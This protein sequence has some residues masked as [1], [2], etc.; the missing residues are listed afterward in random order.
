MLKETLTTLCTLDG[1]SSDEGAVRA[2]LKEKALAAGATVRVDALGNL[3]CEKKGARPAVKP[4]MLCAHMDEVGL[5]VRRCTDEGFV[6]FDAVGGIDRRVLIGKPV[7]VGPKKVPGVIGLQAIHL[8]TKAER[9]KVAKLEEFYIDIGAKSRE[10]AE[11]LVSP[12]DTCS[13]WADTLEF[14][15]GLFKAK[16][17]DD[18]LGCAILCEL[19]NED[20]PTDVTFVFTVQEE[21]GT[22]GAFGATFSVKPEAAL[23]L[24]GT[25]AADL[26]GVADHKKVCYVGK[27]P[28]ISQ[29]DAATIYDR[30]LF[31]MLRNL[32][33]ENKIPWQTKELI[34]GGNDAKA[35]QRS[36][37]GVRVC[38]LSAPV[39]Y[40]HA[41]TS[42]VSLADCENMLKLA[43]LF[44]NAWAKRCLAEHQEGESG[45]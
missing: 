11:T 35:V 32:A 44:V 36:R 27:G 29:I 15:D 23:I 2:W 6:K 3:I 37:E 12:G 26:P 16:A 30:G 45:R 41:P 34:A 17:I 5:M 9:D 22:R 1:V 14:G 40:L 42:V 28:V 33:E 38:A 7:L 43:R 20:Q 31:E 39:R 24:E 4:L 19:L 10:E 18:R 25:T 8:T 21:V 13:F